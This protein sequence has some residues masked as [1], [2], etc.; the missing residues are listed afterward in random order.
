MNKLLW[1][2]SFLLDV[3]IFSVVGLVTFVYTFVETMLIVLANLIMALLMFDFREALNQL[4]KIPI[5]I[6][7]LPIRSWLIIYEKLKQ[8]YNKPIAM[9][10][11][12]D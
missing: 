9:R 11:K 7:V 6:F 5:I 1:F 10:S 4:C 8:C 3:L 2:G 12:E